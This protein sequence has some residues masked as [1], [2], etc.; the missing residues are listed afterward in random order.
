VSDKVGWN[1]LG[2]PCSMRSSHPI[3]L[4]GPAA[5]R[6]RN[7]EEGRHN[8]VLLFYGGALTPLKGLNGEP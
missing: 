8:V 6:Q 7:T 1:S 2:T 3:V 4:F 5:I